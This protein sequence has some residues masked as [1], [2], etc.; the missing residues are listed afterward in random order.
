MTELAE[1]TITSDIPAEVALYMQ[2]LGIPEARLRLLGAGC[3]NKVY[4]CE[5]ASPIFSGG[6]VVRVPECPEAG[7][8]IEANAAYLE[9][10]PAPETLH[11]GRLA[12]NGIPII[13]EEYVDGSPR[14]FSTLTAEEIYALAATVASVH[15]R[16]SSCFSNASG[17]SPICSGTYGDYLQAMLAESVTD[18]LRH[19][20]MGSYIEAEQLVT[21]GMRRLYRLLGTQ[22]SLFGASRFSLLHHDLNP[23]NILW[24]PNGSARLIDWNATFGDAADDVDYVVTNNHVTPQF[25]DTFFNA[26]ANFTGRDDTVARVDAYTLKNQLDDLVWVIGMRQRFAGDAR[27]N[28]AAYEQRLSALEDTLNFT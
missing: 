27:Y 24:T 1:A 21:A 8:S 9:N 26:Y 12:L 3:H 5:E 13:I 23:G 10:T 20:D 11:V 14:D 15:D 19:I 22:T 17:G 18:R 25:R 28:D 6:V 16:T 4:L 7:R 2:D